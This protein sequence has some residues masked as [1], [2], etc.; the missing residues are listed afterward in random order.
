MASSLKESNIE[1]NKE[2]DKIVMPCLAISSIIAAITIIWTYYHSNVIL[3]IGQIKTNYLIIISFLLIL[4]ITIY[5]FWWRFG[6]GK[7]PNCAAWRHENRLSTDLV[8]ETVLGHE[9]KKKA[10]RG[11]LDS[12]DYETHAILN[13][14]YNYHSICKYCDYEWKGTFTRRVKEKL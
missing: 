13:R 8:S 4:S 9:T 10:Y 12:S 11:F 1:K 2:F 3:N 14:K 6:G 7:C 5:L